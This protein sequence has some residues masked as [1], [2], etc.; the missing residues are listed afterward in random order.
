MTPNRPRVLLAEDHAGV[1]KALVD[2]LQADCDVVGVVTDGGNVVAAAA[3]LQPIVALV[4]V[5]LPGV[6]GLEVCRQ[7][8]RDNRQAKVI[9]ISGMLDD[10]I[11][12]EALTAGAVDCIHKARAAS[13]LVAAIASAW[14]ELA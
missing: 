12:E 3:Q 1:I 11:V 4:D 9:M 5:N 6:N 8:T 10:A 14:T 13:E 2:L 7:L